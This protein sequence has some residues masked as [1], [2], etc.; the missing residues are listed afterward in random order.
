M[1]ILL[2]FDNESY[3]YK[4]YNCQA[5]VQVQVQALVP[6][7][8]RP[9]SPRDCFQGGPTLRSLSAYFVVQTQPKILRLVIFIF[10]ILYFIT[11]CGSGC[12]EIAN[13][14]SVRV[15]NTTLTISFEL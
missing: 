3:Y 7:D 6:T 2:M 4:W 8:N 12:V 10:K 11:L 13:T 9:P 15:K 1:K 14:I 5:L